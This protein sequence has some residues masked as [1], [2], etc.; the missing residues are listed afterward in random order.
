MN[1][2]DDSQRDGL[3]AATSRRLARLRA[4]PVDT[5]NLDRRLH[6]LLP[7]A[8][9]ERAGFRLRFSGPMRI[10]ALLLL[11]TGIAAATLYF[12]RDTPAIASPIELVRLHDDALAGRGHVVHVQSLEEAGRVLAQQWSAK[13]DLPQVPGAEVMACCLHEMGKARMAAVTMNADGTPI[14]MAVADA[15]DL[16]SPSSPTVTRDGV[17]WHIQSSGDVN[18]V[19]ARKGDRWICLMGR[20]PTE[21]LMDL[22][23]SVRF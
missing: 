21:K 3:D 14:T 5:T 9:Q 23:Q 10:A 16:R 13:P 6:Q 19:S 12:T 22:A 7:P 11:A 4:L 15:S 8:A 20:A 17:E 2:H 18:M 1:P